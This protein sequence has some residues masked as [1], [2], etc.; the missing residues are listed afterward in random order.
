MKKVF[1][2]LSVFAL[3]IA[4]FGFSAKN[5]MKTNAAT[6]ELFT[7]DPTLSENDIPMYIM[8]SIYTTFPKYYDNV[9]AP[10]A[11]HVGRLYPWNGTKLQVKQVNAQG[12]GFTGKE[13][14]VYFAGS[15]DGESEGNGNNVLF[16]AVDPSTQ[17]K[18]EGT[19]ELDPATGD[20]ALARKSQ[21]A[22][23]KLSYGG[24]NGSAMD[25][26]L[27]HM[28][29]NISGREILITANDLYTGNAT[30]QGYNLYNAALIFDGQGRMVRGVTVD[31]YYAKGNAYNY[32]PEY[33]YVDGVVTKYTD[34]KE[35]DR[36]QVEE[37]DEDGNITMVEGENP[38]YLWGD[39]VWQWVSNDVYESESFAGVNEVAYLAEGWDA[40]KW[41]YATYEKSSNGWVCIAFK[42]AAASS[43]SAWAMTAEQLEVY[44]ATCEANNLPEPTAADGRKVLKEIVIPVDGI[45]YD[46]GYLDKGKM[47]A[48]FSDMFIGGY[49]YG[50]T[51]TAVSVTNDE[52]EVE[53]VEKGMAYNRAFN[54]TTAALV[55]EEKVMN[56]VSYQL[57]D[58]QNVIE[59]LQGEQ[60][61][62]ASL[63]N[64]YG[65]SKYWS[66]EYD[67]TS[68]ISDANLLD[69]YIVVNGS[70]EVQPLAFPTFEEMVEEFVKDLNDFRIKKGGYT[71]QEDG[72]YGK[73]VTTGE[74]AD[75]ETKVE[76]YKMLD[77][78]S[79]ENKIS[80]TSDWYAARSDV[81]DGANSFAGDAEMWK[82]WSWMFEYI[83]SVSSSVFPFDLTNKT[84]GS[85]GSAIY[86]I[87]GFLAEWDM[88][89]GWPSK[90]IDFSNGNAR[91]WVSEKSNSELWSALQID[92]S[93]SHVD[94]NFDVTFRVQH[95][96]TGKTSEVNLTF[97]VVDEYTPILEVDKNALIYA[98]VKSDGKL[99]M[100]EIDPYKIVTAYNA[101][102]NGESIKGDKITHEVQFDADSLVFFANPTEGE[103]QVVA[104]VSQGDKSVTKVFTVYV[105]DMTAPRAYA[106]DV[107]VA[108]GTYLTPSMLLNY[109]Y[110][111]VDGNLLE[112]NVRNWCMFVDAPNTLVPG[113]YDVTILVSDSS[114]NETEV[115]ITV[116][117]AKPA[118]TADDLEDLK[119][120][121]SNQGAQLAVVQGSIEELKE[122]VNSAEEEVKSK[123]GSKS[124]IVVELL[125]ATSLLVVFLRKKH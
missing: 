55:I 110:D 89:S 4:L 63:I 100:P 88:P 34:A 82:K 85:V 52:G 12:N 22:G 11:N 59:V 45:A 119:G 37:V 91:G 112:G 71:L 64:Y 42:G 18:I 104:T 102:Y 125:A 62:P 13:Y 66:D 93:T 105:E 1:V 36:E 60:F 68:F 39:F 109:A 106:D 117:V 30:N 72:T 70:T 90:A 75:K 103:H 19:D 97:V 53:T 21:S 33:C 35:C 14:A 7:E 51:L 101:K 84:T 69:M 25:P 32:V 29:T 38:N 47:D 20:V 108:Y 3:T 95:T 116:T 113:T 9:N 87:W 31:G 94:K 6:S 74:G 50:R 86:V 23:N 15:L 24:D 78:P 67:L 92:T 57:L 76:T 56:D 122:L 120:E 61:K 10:D 49:R 79:L 5:S 58:G 2:F 111:N 44:K 114:A 98:P 17:S 40:N 77:I 27:S 26:S 121:I 99:I 48:Q 124:A 65:V 28:R 80:T 8:N 46:Y 96:V 81:F 43:S 83:N 73:E 16:Y 41:D 54:Y 115:N 107:T 123:C 118:V